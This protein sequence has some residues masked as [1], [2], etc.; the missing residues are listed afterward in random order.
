MNEY[1]IDATELSMQMSFLIR[2]GKLPPKDC[3]FVNKLIK[4][5]NKQKNN[6]SRKVLRSVQSKFEK[7]QNKY[8]R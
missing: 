7:L 2:S 1:K 4:Q 3:L 8:Q 6:V 5:L